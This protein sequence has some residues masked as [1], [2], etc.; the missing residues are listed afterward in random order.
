M[1]WNVEIIPYSTVISCVVPSEFS[2][3]TSGCSASTN[4]CTT[5]STQ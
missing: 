5:L 2:I 4:T 3:D 1:M